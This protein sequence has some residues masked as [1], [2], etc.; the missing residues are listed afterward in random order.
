MLAVDDGG[1]RRKGAE[2]AGIEVVKAGDL[3]ERVTSAGALAVVVIDPLTLSQLPENGG[4]TYV[5]DFCSAGLLEH[6]DDRGVWARQRSRLVEA[7]GSADALIVSGAL[8]VPHYLAWALIAKRDVLKMPIRVASENAILQYED[9][10][11]VEPG[12]PGTSFG[13]YGMW[14]Y[15]I[16]EG[17]EDGVEWLPLIGGYDARANPDWLDAYNENRDG[18]QSM[19][20]RHRT[21]LLETFNADD[22]IFIRFRLPRSSPVG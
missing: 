15:V 22:V 14:D 18:D 21:D 20:V 1:R 19:F 12:D 17:T 8:K 13:D 16:V 10:A 5:L 7:I 6:A 11:I 2:V 9:V 3:A 4:F